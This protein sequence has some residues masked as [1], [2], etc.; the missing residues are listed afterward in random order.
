MNV[1]FIPVRGGSK[2]IPK[3]NIKIM[4]GKP[5]LYWVIDAACKCNYIDKVFVCTES[6]EIQRTVETFLDRDESYKKIEIVG[7]SEESASDTASTEQVMLEF[8]EKHE[9]DAI[10]LIQAT[11]PLLQTLDLDKGFKL[12]N[13]PGT[14]S[15]LSVVH[16][17]RFNWQ[18]CDD[19]SVKPINYDAFKRPRRQDFG[20]YLVENGAFY[21]TSREQLMRTHNRISG[22]IK[23]VEMDEESFFEVDEEKDWRIIESLLLNRE[24]Q[25][26]IARIPEVKIFLT[27]VDGCLTDGGMYYSNS[28]DELKKFNTKDGMGLKMLHE[29]GVIT[30]IIT[31]EDVIL[32][33]RRA[34]KLELDIYESGCQNKAKRISEI[35]EEYNIPMDN[36][37]YVGDDKNDEEALKSVGFS[38]CPNDAN[39]LICKIVDYKTVTKGGQGA[40]REIADLILRE[41]R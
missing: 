33:E 19:G 23:C 20:G 29:K 10:A 12:Y 21:I 8:A 35:S 17:Y 7:R 37:C 5:L 40:I 31:G 32:N 18:Y 22:S 34:K 30:G 16:Q 26:R 38:C 4:A 27:D 1:A 3:K 11:S 41:I 2:S 36:I 24:Q 9:F 6:I 39:D 28:G 13:S 25:K 14:D 15:V